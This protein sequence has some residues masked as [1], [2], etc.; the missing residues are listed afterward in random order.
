MK[1]KLKSALMYITIIILLVTRYVEYK[2]ISIHLPLTT[3]T[4]LAMI[5]LIV[6]VLLKN[7]K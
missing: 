7:N 6:L 5:V 2:N 3:I 1:N 4:D